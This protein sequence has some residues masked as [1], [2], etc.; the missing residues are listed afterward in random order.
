MHQK[1][2]YFHFNCNRLMIFAKNLWYRKLFLRL[3]DWSKDNIKYFLS[4]YL[5]LLRLK[6]SLDFSPA[7]YLA[8]YRIAHTQFQERAL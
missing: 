7:R 6:R 2:K 1:N 8:L 3:Q 5:L 4:V